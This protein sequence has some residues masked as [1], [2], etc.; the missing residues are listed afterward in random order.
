MSKTHTRRE[1][2]GQRRAPG[3]A[4]RPGWGHRSSLDEG[5]R[6]LRLVHRHRALHQLAA[7]GGGRGGVRA[8][9]HEGVEVVGAALQFNR[10]NLEDSV[11]SLVNK[12]V[13]RIV[14]MPCFLFPG[15]HFTE[16]IP[17]LVEQLKCRY[18]EVQFMVADIPGVDELFTGLV[19]KRIEEC[20]PELSPLA[21]FT[22]KS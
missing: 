15:R 5:E 17:Q 16:H 12:A 4:G 8:L 13:N 1:V 18:P 21:N 10:P 3:G 7:R 9:L 2:L 6:H 19:A 20:V 11:A 22:D 14:I